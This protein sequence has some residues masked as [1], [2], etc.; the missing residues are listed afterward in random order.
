VTP[1]GALTGAGFYQDLRTCGEK[2]PQWSRFSGRACDPVG[3]PRWSS[4]FL[5]GCIPW[6][7]PTLGQFVESCSPCEGLTLQNIVEN[8]LL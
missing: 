8:C 6:E 7:G 1:W 5:K 4:L 3:D 2:T